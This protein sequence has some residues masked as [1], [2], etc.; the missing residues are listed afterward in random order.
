MLKRTLFLFFI[1]TLAGRL[2]SQESQKLILDLAHCEELAFKNNLSIQ[3]AQLGLQTA[4]AKLTQASH[5]RFLPK[6][7]IRNVWGPSP[8]ARGVLDPS[9]GFVISSDTSVGLSD[10]QYFTQ[11]DLDL[12]QPIFTFGKLSSAVHA[13]RFG[14]EAEQANFAGERE[15]IRFQVRQLYWGLI[16]AKE[17]LAVVEDADTELRKAEN[18]LQEK[19]DE[20]SDE[21]SQTDL[22]K[23]QIFRYEIDKRYREA[24]DNIALTKSALKSALGLKEDAQIDLVTEYLEPLEVK[25]DSLSTYVDMAMQNRSELARLRAGIQAKGALVTL[26][27]SDYFPQIFFGGQLRYN[28][29][30]DRFDPRNPFIY[31]PTNFFRPGFVVGANLDLN[32]LHTRDKVRVAQAEFQQVAR[33][34]QQLIDGI[35]LEVEKTYL[36]LLQAQHNMQE[37]N[38]ALKASDNWLRSETMTFDIGI[39]EV[40]DLIDAF[41]ASGA[42]QAEHYQNVFKLN[43]SIAKLSKATGRDLYA[44]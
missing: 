13:A 10:L 6:F 31:N 29:A 25:L 3:N 41:K 33:R 7:E 32:F 27:K 24:L 44:K 19:L 2:L 5:A 28:Y 38:K 15:N 22:F 17:L 21:V 4:E 18:K 9:G 12:V 16:L 1:I 35:K 42:L 36:E 40:K 8:P 43:V 11:V 30:K 14:V 39:G 37:S 26:S 34:E 20:G 23:V